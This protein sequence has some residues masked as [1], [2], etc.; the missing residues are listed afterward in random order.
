MTAEKEDP[1]APQHA[2]ECL[3]FGK[4]FAK[5]SMTRHVARCP[6]RPAATASRT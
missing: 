3:L 4:T 1:K 6:E 5:R 2:G